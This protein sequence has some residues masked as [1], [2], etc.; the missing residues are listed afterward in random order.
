MTIVIKLSLRERTKS[1]ERTGSGL[2]KR[3]TCLANLDE[4]RGT[5]P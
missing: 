3:K 5:Y 1:M 2:K 4:I